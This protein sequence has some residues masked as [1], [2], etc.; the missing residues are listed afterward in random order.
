MV[1][2]TGS[3]ARPA[4]PAHPKGRPVALL[5]TSTVEQLVACSLSGPAIGSVPPA[6]VSPISGADAEDHQTTCSSTDAELLTNLAQ[7]AVQ[8]VN[9]SAVLEPDSSCNEGYYV[10]KQNLESAD[11]LEPAPI[12][13]GKLYATFRKVRYILFIPSQLL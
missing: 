3:V 7:A 10:A 5:N 1:R 2:N 8:P 13:R 6:S 9:L 12:Q 4:R 11:Q